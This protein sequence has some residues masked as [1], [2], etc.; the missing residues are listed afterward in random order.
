MALNV[1]EEGPGARG[2][3][4]MGDVILSLGGREVTSAETLHA[5]LDPS[6]VGKELPVSVL[7]GGALVTLTV[8]IAE[9]PI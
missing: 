3:M 5:V 7:R 2:G 1:A 4:L 6:T 8:T 9:R